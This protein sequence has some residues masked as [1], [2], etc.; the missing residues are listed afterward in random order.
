MSPPATYAALPPPKPSSESQKKD[1][2]KG[3]E[4]GSKESQSQKL[5][6]SNS[7]ENFAKP[8]ISSDSYVAILKQMFPD[9]DENCICN[10]LGDSPS[11]D[12]VGPL[13]DEMAMKGYP[14]DGASRN[15]MEEKE[16]GEKEDSKPSR[17]F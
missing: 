11:V 15:R 16:F 3:Q 17:T 10:R 12:Q 5:G 2:S 9:A 1:S 14:K 6:G 13:A 7:N 8:P 4:E